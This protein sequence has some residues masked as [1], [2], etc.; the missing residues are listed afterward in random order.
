MMNFK[1][2]VMKEKNE[3]DA[4]WLAGLFYEAPYVEDGDMTNGNVMDEI[5]LTMINNR[6]YPKQLNISSETNTI[7]NGKKS[8][9]YDLLISKLAK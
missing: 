6:P 2:F 9:R 1:N 7:S 4:S 8:Y 5:V 3:R